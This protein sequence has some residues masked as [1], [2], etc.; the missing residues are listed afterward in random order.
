[1]GGV[2]WRIQ[3]NEEKDCSLGHFWKNSRN[4]IFI[5]ECR[6]TNAECG[7]TVTDRFVVIMP[8]SPIPSSAFEKHHLKLPT[9]NTEPLRHGRK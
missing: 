5:D 6:P 9:K 4:A 1:M 2:F 8:H 3:E 7:I